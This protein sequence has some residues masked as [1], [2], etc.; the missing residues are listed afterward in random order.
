M[1]WNTK[2][3]TYHQGRT[4]KYG[5]K[6]PDALL[7]DMDEATKDEFIEKGWLAEDDAPEPE[8][9]TETE[10]DSE[11]DPQVVRDELFNELKELGLKPHHNAGLPK[12]QEM[13]EKYLAEQKGD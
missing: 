7:D 8:P 12:L 9:E 11:P 6:L 5:D 2:D 1:K 10:P 13:K 3:V 4:F